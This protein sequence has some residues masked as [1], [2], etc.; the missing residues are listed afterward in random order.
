[1]TDNTALLSSL[2][3]FT[4]VT[5]LLLL[6]GSFVYFLRKRRNRAATSHAL[7]MDDSTKRSGP[8]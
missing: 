5:V 2:N 1:M 7:G 3:L 4:L 6:I 8:L